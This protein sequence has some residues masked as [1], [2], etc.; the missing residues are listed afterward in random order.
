[1]TDEDPLAHL[2]FDVYIPEDVVDVSQLDNYELSCYE[3]DTRQSLIS[4]GQMHAPA[5]QRTEEGKHLHSVFI[6]CQIEMK[7]RLADA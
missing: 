2:D 6:A 4:T 1:M 3:R 5:D 7:K